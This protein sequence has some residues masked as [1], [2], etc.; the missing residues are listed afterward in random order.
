MK[1][2]LRAGYLV[3]IGL[4]CLAVALV[5]W[6]WQALQPRFDGGSYHYDGMEEHALTWPLRTQS[7]EGQ[8][9]VDMRFALEF[10]AVRA[11]V[12]QWHLD[13]C[14]ETMEINGT[15][16]SEIGTDFCN[17]D[18]GHAIDLSRYL[19]TG[20]NDFHIRLKDTGGLLR[21]AMEIA[22]ADPFRIA[23]MVWVALLFLSLGLY[24]WKTPLWKRPVEL[25]WIFLAGTL[26]RW[27]YVIGTP[28][29]MR[30]HDAD[31]HLDYIAYVAKHFAIPRADDGWEFHQPPLYYFITGLYQH[32]QELAGRAVPL[33]VRDLQWLSLALSAATLAV[34]LWM[35]LQLFRVTRD[36][37]GAALFL[38]ILAAF[39]G[40]VFVASRV[41]NDALFGFLA[42]LSLALTQR[43]W[44][45]GKSLDWVLLSVVIGVAFITKVNAA[46]LLGAALLCLL[47]RKKT[48]WRI[49]L[50]L[51]AALVCMV[52]IISGWVFTARILEAG[53]LQRVISLGNGGMNG[54]LML[55]TTPQTFLTLNPVQML[56]HPYNNPWGP[57]E[58]REY[59]WEFFLR[60]AVSGEFGYGD[61][62]KWL[63]TLELALWLGTL[64]L[65][66]YGFVRVQRKEWYA[67]LPLTATLLT[68]V[69]GSIAYRADHPCACNQDFRF[70]P[71]LIVPVAYFAV[72]G[73]LLLPG[74]AKELGQAWLIVLATT[75]AILL[76]AATLWG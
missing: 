35:S 61:T 50:E 1:R 29:A 6:G 25:L 19:Q 43:W 56:A 73:A 27:F 34:C 30:A 18:P 2:L 36:R 21:I 32:M 51:G 72:R 52:V 14:V 15:A 64:G 26:L 65:G 5:A 7:V 37:R 62:L 67:L 46:L 8:Q 3:D 4:F 54:S 28:Y 20:R 33:I 38:G 23:C 9:M 31:A 55:E 10:P 75:S 58:R 71:L 47:L 49:K 76:S 42:F 12:Y 48:A 13:D 39:P 22:P 40:L 45:T 63:D 41:S 74:R 60:S 24:V 68:Q 66:V 44:K 17:Y 16:V 57:G 11:H 59:Y 69:A 70:V 53:G